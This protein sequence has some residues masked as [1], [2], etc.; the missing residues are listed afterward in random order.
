LPEDTQ[1]LEGNQAPHTLADTQELGDNQRLADTQE[2]A[3]DQGPDRGTVEPRT[4][5]DN[6]AQWD[7]AVPALAQLEE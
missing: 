4:L 7:T 6:Q 5:V 2:L 1:G 3:A